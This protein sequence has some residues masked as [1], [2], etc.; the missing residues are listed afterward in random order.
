MSG[1]R[2]NENDMDGPNEFAGSEVEKPIAGAI[3]AIPDEHAPECFGGEFVH[4]AVI[5]ADVGLAAENL[6]VSEVSGD[7]I[8]NDVWNTARTCRCS[9]RG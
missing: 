9:G 3:I 2:F 5:P 7:T 8:E 1:L 6:N 4:V